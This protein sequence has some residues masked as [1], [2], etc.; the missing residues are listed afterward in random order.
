MV[1][2][3]YNGA[4]IV[5]RFMGEAH[6]YFGGKAGVMFEPSPAWAHDATTAKELMCKA[7][8]YNMNEVSY[9]T[10]LGNMNATA[11]APAMRAYVTGNATFCSSPEQ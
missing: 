4:N 8:Q 11:W 1:L 7:L 10:N 5:E 9:W 6:S 2:W 3:F